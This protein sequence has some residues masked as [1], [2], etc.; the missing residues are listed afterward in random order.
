[1]RDI[2]T[3]VQEQKDA[4]I[5]RPI[6]LYEVYLGSQ[7]AV[8]DNTIFFA[9]HP[10]IVKFFDVE[11][12]PQDF[13]PIGIKRSAVKHN[14]DLAV[15]Y[16]NITYDNV[17]RGMGALIA[18][19]DFRNKR[20]ILKTVFLDKLDS[21]DDATLI[22][23]GVMDKPVITQ[24]TFGVQVV[25]RLTLQNRTGR[26]Y[27]L[28]CP[29]RFGQAHCAYPINTTKATGSVSAGSTSSLI[30][31]VLRTEATDHWKHGVIHFTS[32]QNIGVKRRV[33]G[34]DFPTQEISIDIV[35]QYT[36]AV[37]DTYDIYQGCDKTLDWCTRLVNTV[38]YGGFHTLPV[39]VPENL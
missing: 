28:M 24:N 6:D 30:I 4:D 7:T 22:F 5:S 8:D 32:G 35:L 16:F 23:D 33:T 14:I 17:D 38:N 21:P 13:L 1:M 18:Q 36:P 2:S 12:T 37:G 10:D 15:D 27:Q 31:D 9:S 29:W 3:N 34:Y 20:V 25:S 26:L 39:E 11:S 19:T